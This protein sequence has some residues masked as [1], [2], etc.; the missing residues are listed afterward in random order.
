MLRIL[1]LLFFAGP[2]LAQPALKELSPVKKET[3]PPG[4]PTVVD[5]AKYRFYS[6][7][8]YTGPV[9]WIVDGTSCGI[10]EVDK[11]LTLFGLVQGQ[12]D[13]AEY[14][15]PAGAVIVWGKSAGTTKVQALGV[16]KDKPVI[17][18]SLAFMTGPAPPE[19][20]PTPT[21]TPTPQPATTFRVI[22][23][24][25]SSK[26]LTKEQN[27]VVGAAEVQK[28]LNDRCTKDGATPG[29][30][31]FDPQTTAANEYAGIRAMWDASKVEAAKQS[32]VIV[33]RNE[34]IDVV[35]FP[36]N[37]AEALKTLKTYG[38]N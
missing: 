10:K 26:N 13:P 25:E 20:T 12:T 33:Q 28:Y 27:A 37:V 11:P 38:G 31:C 21:P 5:V 3:P 7:D 18:L 4:V 35:P 22:F 2:C 9:T 36:A 6:V 23:C 34:K 14:P 15:I 32:C 19:P 8:G 29:W 16:V 24:T 30:R 17:L 1:A